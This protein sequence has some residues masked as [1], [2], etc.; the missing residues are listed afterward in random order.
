MF[1]LN[2]LRCALV[3]NLRPDIGTKTQE[4]N[5]LHFAIKKYIYILSY[6]D[7]KP[8]LL[9]V[10][11]AFYLFICLCLFC[12]F[13]KLED[14]LNCLVLQV[15]KCPTPNRSGDLINRVWNYMQDNCDAFGGDNT[16]HI[17]KL[18]AGRHKFISCN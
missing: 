12:S 6:T 13:R 9:S 7:L 15:T 14:N 17:R 1:W 11:I 3:H 18:F 2:I 4:A 8:V 16:L 5:L 10:Y